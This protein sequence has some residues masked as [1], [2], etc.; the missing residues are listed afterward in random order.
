MVLLL[1]PLHHLVGGLRLAFHVLIHF[2]QLHMMLVNQL[3]RVKIVALLLLMHLVHP[4]AN[5]RIITILLHF[6]LIVEALDLH[7]VPLLKILILLG[8]PL[9]R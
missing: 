9:N 1:N 7:V 2:L 3:L 6:D 4:S 5:L 8:M